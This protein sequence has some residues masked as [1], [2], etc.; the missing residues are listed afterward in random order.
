MPPTPSCPCSAQTTTSCMLK[1]RMVRVSRP[2]VLLLSNRSRTRPRRRG[3][4][5]PVKGSTTPRRSR[6][7]RSAMAG[8]L[9]GGNA[10]PQAGNPF[11]AA[12]AAAR[13]GG[14][15][16]HPHPGQVME[17]MTGANPQPAAPADQ[18]K[19]KSPLCGTHGRTRQPHAADPRTAAVITC[20]TVSNTCHTP[21]RASV[22]GV[23]HFYVAFLI[24]CQA[25]KQQGAPILDIFI[26]IY[27]IGLI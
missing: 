16:K 18:D 19:G 10:K 5:W 7:R 6:R 9:F 11:Q 22:T 27:P 20:Q 23:W 21:K 25:V 12:M 14:G 1:A 8:S 3:G 24:T 17:K 15:L 2:S 13:G 26:S 4:M